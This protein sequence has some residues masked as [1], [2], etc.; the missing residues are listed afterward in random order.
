M[1]SPT[2]LAIREFLE[3]HSP[4][5]ITEAGTIEAAVAVMLLFRDAADPEVLLIRRAKNDRDPWSGQ[6]ALPGGRREAGDETLLVTAC[7]ET[8]EETGVTLDRD[9]LIGELD[10]LHPRTPVLPPVVV[11][12]FVFALAER[13]TVRTNPEATSHMWVSVSAL[14]EGAQMSQVIV[15]GVRLDVP[16]FVVGDDVV[17]GMTERIIRPIIELH[18]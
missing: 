5:R 15:R 16:S 2:L 18:H 3:Q 12:P 7:R 13:P 11:R 9:T 8:L 4:R 14:K 6:I 1:G 17:W 10:D